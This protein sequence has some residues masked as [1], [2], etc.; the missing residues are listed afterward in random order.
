MPRINGYC[1][2]LNR[3]EKREQ[4]ASDVAWLLLSSIGFYD[5]DPNASGG[6]L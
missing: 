2:Q 4:V 3:V 5:L 1:T 6:G